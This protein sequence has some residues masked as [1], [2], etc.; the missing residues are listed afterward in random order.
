MSGRRAS[1]W[2]DEL[3]PYQLGGL[4]S[5]GGQMTARVVAGSVLAFQLV[6]LGTTGSGSPDVYPRA[7]GWTNSGWWRAQEN[8]PVSEPKRSPDNDGSPQC[9]EFDY[10]STA[11]VVRDLHEISGLTWEQIAKLFSVSRRAV[12]LWAAGKPM[13]AGHEELLS[14]LLRIAKALP[15]STA[16]QRR[17]A[18]LR[19]GA[20]GPSI[21]DQLRMD[22]ANAQVLKQSSFRHVV[23]EARQS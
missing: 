6:G 2:I 20:S 23:E 16:A 4:P 10:S 3:G 9:Q 8:R 7:I 5:I 18:M 1:Y 21:Y 22:R 15:G 13:N 14:G 12:H 19:P 11:I 17:S